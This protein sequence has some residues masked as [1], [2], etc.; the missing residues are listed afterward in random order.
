[1]P[2][3]DSAELTPACKENL[4]KPKDPD[5]EKKAEKK[6]KKAAEGKTGDD[7]PAGDKPAETT[8]ADKPAEGTVRL[9]PIRHH[10]APEAEKAITP[11]AKFAY[12]DVD[13]GVKP[14]DALLNLFTSKSY[15]M[16]RFR[17]RAFSK[18]IKQ[19]LQ[20]EHFD[21]VNMEGSFVSLYLPLVR[22]LTKVPVIS[23]QPNV[24]WEIWERLAQ[25]ETSPLKRWYIA[26]LARRMKT[27]EIQHMPAFDEVYAITDSDAK[28]F[29][30]HRLQTCGGI[31]CGNGPG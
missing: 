9:W 2:E 20:N 19:T 11:Y 30:Q 23:R 25:N 4:D 12:V 3:S 7:F 24:E 10:P 27:F 28:A 31:A 5:R 14:V 29:S 21:I 26:L 13:T 17:S 1:M 18:L 6:A 16:E 22:S 8:L 15:N